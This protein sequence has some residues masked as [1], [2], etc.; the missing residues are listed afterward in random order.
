MQSLVGPSQ[1]VHNNTGNKSKKAKKNLVQRKTT[2]SI[3]VC[4]FMYMHMHCVVH[5]VQ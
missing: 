3:E 4:F 5:T 1:Q 2:H